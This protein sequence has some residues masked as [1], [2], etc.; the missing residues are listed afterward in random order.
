M[1]YYRHSEQTRGVPAGLKA[2]SFVRVNQRGPILDC[3][4]HDCS[5]RSRASQEVAKVHV[6]EGKRF[7]RH[8]QRPDLCHEFAVGAGQDDR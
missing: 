3:R 2:G 5:H 6:A 7:A 4:T 8:A 1:G